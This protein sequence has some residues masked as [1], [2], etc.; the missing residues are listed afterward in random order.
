MVWLVMG[1]DGLVFLII[2]AV[3]CQSDVADRDKD[4]GRER[5]QHSTITHQV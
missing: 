1:K 2:F 4:K 5:E 3:E